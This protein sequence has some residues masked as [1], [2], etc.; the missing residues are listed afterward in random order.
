MVGLTP[1]LGAGRHFVVQAAT[2]YSKTKLRKN[3]FFYEIAAADRAEGG[4]VAV[5]FALVTHLGDQLI[6]WP[7]IMFNCAVCS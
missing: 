4:Q 3:H 6:F 2:D 1:I 7:R 5:F